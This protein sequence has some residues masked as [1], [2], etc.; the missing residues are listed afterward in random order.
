M[1]R[2]PNATRPNANTAGANI[3]GI[4]L[5]GRFAPKPR[6]LTRY[7]IAI[8]AT[9]VKPSQYAEKLPATKPTGC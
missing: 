1:P 2:N 3:S 7:A 9:I 8:S 6:V 5:P 4:A